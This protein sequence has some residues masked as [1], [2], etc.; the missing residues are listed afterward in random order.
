MA[1]WGLD[2]LLSLPVSL[3]QLTIA[4]FAPLRARCI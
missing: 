3:T 4:Q 1:A 2:W